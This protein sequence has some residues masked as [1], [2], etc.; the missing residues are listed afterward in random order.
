[1][2]SV[3]LL[4]TKVYEKRKYLPGSLSH[5]NLRVTFVRSNLTHQTPET[6]HKTFL[7]VLPL[8]KSTPILFL[9]YRFTLFSRVSRKI[10]DGDKYGAKL[11]KKHVK[12]FVFEKLNVSFVRKFFKKMVLEKSNEEVFFYW[13]A[14]NSGLLSLWWNRSCFGK[15]LKILFSREI[16]NLT[17]SAE[18]NRQNLVASSERY[19]DDIC[20][21]KG[22]SKEGCSIGKDSQSEHFN[23]EKKWSNWLRRKILTI[24]QIIVKMQQN[25]VLQEDSMTF[26]NSNVCTNAILIY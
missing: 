20:E 7:T 3:R 2:F 13:K 5:I 23:I 25:N 21:D 12:T 18:F 15:K 11:K 24:C 1:M 17:R 26:W 16:L 4:R 14:F 10:W 19:K 6:N 8:T 9:K 22:A